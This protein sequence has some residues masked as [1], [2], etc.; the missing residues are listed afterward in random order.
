MGVAHGFV[1]GL[2]EGLVLFGTVVGGVA[3]GFYALGEDLGGFGLGL[4]EIDG[5]GDE[6]FE[7]HGAWVGCLG[8]AHELGLDVGWDDLDDF[9]V[10]GAELVAEGLAPGVDGGL[11]GVI[12]GG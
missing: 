9:D 7:G 1:E 2:E 8:T 3:E 6:V 12:R 11:G 4:D 10:G 5:L